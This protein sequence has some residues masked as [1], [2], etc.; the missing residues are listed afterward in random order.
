MDLDARL[1]RYFVTVAE[2]G[3][4][5]RA[6][7]RLG[8]Q[9]PP[10]SQ[11]IRVLEERVGATLLRRKARGV[12]L[13]DAGRAMLQHARDALAGIDRAVDAARRAARGE[14]G[15][16]AIG[17]APTAPFHPLVPQAIR[18]FRQVYPS[19]AVSLEEALTD[20]LVA[21]LAAGHID[22]AVVR[23]RLCGPE[24]LELV[25]LLDEAMIIALPVGWLRRTAGRR[26]TLPL[27]R[28]A[29]EPFVV[30]GPP[31]SGIHDATVAACARAGFAPRI[32]QLAPRFTSALGLVSAGLG[33]TLVPRS[34]RRFDLDGVAYLSIAGDAPPTVV[35]GMATRRFE[36]SAT[37]RNFVAIARGR[38]APAPRRA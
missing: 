36:P 35:L 9:Q 20:E 28:L 3:H 30:Y 10:L 1:L 29:D 19:V 17:M 15:R 33:A 31:G 14:E 22:V 27:E 6:A 13:T 2:E 12:E 16:I 24:P 32:V 37:V 7:E 25:P 8:I 5:T 18:A 4:V 34:M 38:A 26:S 23:N 21:R 11:Q